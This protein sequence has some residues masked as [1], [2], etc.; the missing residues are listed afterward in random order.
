MT[1]TL[2][3]ILHYAP[4]ASFAAEWCSVVNIPIAVVYCDVLSNNKNKVAVLLFALGGGGC[5]AVNE[6]GVGQIIQIH[7]SIDKVS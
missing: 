3:L 2:L 1:D 6:D 5:F 4:H 7:H